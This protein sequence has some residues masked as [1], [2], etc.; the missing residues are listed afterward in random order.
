MGVHLDNGHI[1]THLWWHFE[2]LT[3]AHMQTNRHSQRQ[4]VMHLH[5]LG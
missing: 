5:T 2:H 1:L 3:S 4:L